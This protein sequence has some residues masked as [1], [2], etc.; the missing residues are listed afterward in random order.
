MSLQVLCEGEFQKN[1]ITISLN[2]NFQFYKDYV[3]P[4]GKS[5]T[6]F[7]VKQGGIFTFSTQDNSTMNSTDDT[8]C[9]MK[10]TLH[11]TCQSMYFD[12]E[13]FQLGQG[14][15]LFVKNKYKKY[16]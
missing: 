14:E 4:V 1:N 9:E 13:T 3:C 5:S 7:E 8:N 10:Y 12:C 2:H 6:L 15:H 11:K 16:R